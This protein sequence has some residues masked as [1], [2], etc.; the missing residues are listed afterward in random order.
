MPPMIQIAAA[1]C[2]R[3]CA[4]AV[5]KVG[6]RGTDLGINPTTTPRRC[7]L[8]ETVGLRTCIPLCT[9][10]AGQ[11]S[12]DSNPEPPS[13]AAT[14][15]I[16]CCGWS[17]LK[18]SE[19]AGQLRRQYS[20]TLQA[21]AQLFD[22][23]EINSTF[24]RLPRITTARK[25]REEAD[26]I[27]PRFIF[28]VKAYRG[29]THLHRFTGESFR[30]FDQLKA[31]CQALRSAVLLFQSSASFRP[32]EASLGSMRSFFGAIDRGELFCV[33]EP[34]GKW[35]DQPAMIA[36]L[37]E[38]LDLVHCVDPLRNRPTAFGKGQLAHFRLHGFG[39]P[40]MYRYEFSEEELKR[41]AAVTGS[42]GAQ[43]R[44]AY[45][46]FNNV[47]CYRDGLEYRR[48]ACAG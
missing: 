13:M 37:C 43:V 15:Q 36:E 17:Y 14:V 28:T 10:S 33:W 19:F 20:S 31:V 21:Y 30:F 16:G 34:R 47:S 38:E 27:N 44:T 3:S 39:K 12:C 29:I 7:P 23:V 1:G 11:F 46:F 40:S 41:I 18:E 5:E 35:Y 2:K 24:Y 8:P 45:L 4:L 48:L 26:A 42:L 32:T 6:F 22:A 25:W 9:F